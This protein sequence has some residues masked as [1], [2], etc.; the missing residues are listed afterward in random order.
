MTDPTKD[1]YQITIVLA[2]DP[3]GYLVNNYIRD[4]VKE[5]VTEIVKQINSNKDFKRTKAVFMRVE[6]PR[7]LD[8]ADSDHTFDNVL[9]IQY[10]NEFKR[11]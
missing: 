1:F 8:Y 2:S 6:E 9:H 5:H 11:Y 4:L 7:H 3:E 10:Q